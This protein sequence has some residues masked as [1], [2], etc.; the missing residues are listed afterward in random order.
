MMTG[1]EFCCS[2]EF[3]GL[4]R[5]W[6]AAKMSVHVKTIE[7]WEGISQSHVP[8]RAEQ[9]M[10]L[11]LELAERTVAKMTLK[12]EGAI[13]VPHG[14]TALDEKFPA[15]FHRMIAARVNERT[16]SGIVYKEEK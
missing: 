16:K 6:V 8:E 10:N 14:R 1:A 5:Q 11:L 3:L 12:W 7:T 9:F 15:S 13:P 2:R 4:P